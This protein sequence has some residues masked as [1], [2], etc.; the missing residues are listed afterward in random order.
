MESEIAGEILIKGQCETDPRYGTEPENRPLDSYITN[1]VI[2]LDKPSGPS[3]HQVSSWVKKILGVEKAG[4]S[5]TLDP[6]VTGVLPVAIENSTKILKTLLLATK[7][8][9]C[10]MSLHGDVSD[11]KL[12]EVLRYFHG[13]IY[14]KPPLKSAVKRRLRIKT[15]YYIDLIER[16]GRDVLFR[17]GCE[18]GTYIRKMCRDIGLVLGTGAHMQELRRTKAGPFDENSLVTLH[19]LKDA[20][21]FYRDSGDESELRRYIL[22]VESAVKHLKR[23]WINDGAVD[24]LCHGADLNAP[25]ICRMDSRIELSNIVAIFT[26][27]NELVAI[28]SSLRSSSEIMDMRKGRVVDM[29][30]VIMP[31]STYPRKWNLR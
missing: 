16:D 5:G 7:E 17:V 12:K 30:R 23:I 24:A 6:A 18:A 22:P 31:P 2:N 11:E 26:L 19:D 13:K 27:K 8:Y 20:Y 15:I 21:E 14:Q 9:V 25:G 10:L 29:E 4:H 28:G 3:S 1:G